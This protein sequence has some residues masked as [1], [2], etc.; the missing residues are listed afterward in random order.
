MRLN[1]GVVSVLLFLGLAVYGLYKVNK[2]LKV[3]KCELQE[4]QNISCALVSLE[5][6]I[7]FL[8]SAIAR[9][10]LEDDNKKYFDDD[11]LLDDTCHGSDDSLSKCV[12]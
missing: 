10:D 3:S 7:K 2:V 6:E 1:C 11:D 4:V 9:T 5:S 8:S 12:G